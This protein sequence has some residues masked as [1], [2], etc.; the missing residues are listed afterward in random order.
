MNWI[1]KIITLGQSGNILILLF[2]ISYHGALL[3]FFIKWV[4]IVEHLQIRW[5][6]LA[7]TWIYNQDGKGQTESWPTSQRH[8][9]W[10]EQTHG[11]RK[12]NVYS[13]KDL[14]LIHYVI[15]CGS[16]TNKYLPT[17]YHRQ[18]V[19]YFSTH[20]LI[21]ESQRDYWDPVLS[22]TNQNFTEFLISYHH[23]NSV[24][25]DIFLALQGKCN[26]LFISLHPP[27]IQ[28]MSQF[29]VCVMTFTC[30]DINS[31]VSF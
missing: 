1:A 6:S 29:S 3:P 24:S 5:R 11:W 21:W 27:N 9:T 30:L 23:W 14:H 22:A 13:R 19:P 28:L 16:S 17:T 18:A 7:V 12:T 8:K 15:I 25:K 26:S 20:N 4:W 31:G 2:E 10:A